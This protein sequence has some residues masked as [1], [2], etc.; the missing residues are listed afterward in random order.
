M[1]ALLLGLALLSAGP[2]HAQF[3]DFDAE[4]HELLGGAVGA[5]QRGEARNIIELGVFLQ[6]VP[7]DQGD[8]ARRPRMEIAKAPIRGLRDARQAH[9]RRQGARLSAGAHRPGDPGRG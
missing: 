5:G 7:R 1:R 8:A 9:G 3:I 2:A 4:G 6:Q